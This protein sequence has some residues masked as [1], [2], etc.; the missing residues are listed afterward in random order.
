MVEFINKAKERDIINSKNMSIG[1]T[2]TIIREGETY[3]GT[4][5]V[6]IYSCD[7]DS[8]VSLVA[9]NDG[10]RTWTDT[11][12]KVRLCDFELREI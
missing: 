3:D 1:Q 5:I 6:R 10:S 8:I 7:S 4:P 9:L 11:N 2:G 12:F